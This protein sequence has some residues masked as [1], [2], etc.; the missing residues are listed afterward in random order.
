MN[1]LSLSNERTKLVRR[2]QQIPFYLLYFFSV[3]VF[4][5][6]VQL[7]ILPFT[8]SAKWAKH[9]KEPDWIFPIDIIV[10]SM[11][12]IEVGVQMFVTIKAGG[13][14]WRDFFYS[15][16]RVVGF[17]VACIS[18]VMIVLDI[19]AKEVSKDGEDG[20][21]DVPVGRIDLFRDILRGVRAFEFL[22]MLREVQENPEWHMNPSLSSP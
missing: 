18:T 1:E 14:G 5:L 10:T 4:F 20:E 19:I 7:G 11:L 17:I 16:E 12:V 13:K 2:A 8:I 6:I 21:I 15:R 22:E 3:Y 9:T